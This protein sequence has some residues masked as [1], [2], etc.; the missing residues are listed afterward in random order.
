MGRNAGLIGWMESKMA[1]A[2]ATDK[3]SFELYGTVN[4]VVDRKATA[5][6]VTGTWHKHVG[7]TDDDGLAAAIDNVIAAHKTRLDSLQAN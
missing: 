6:R 2:T 5:G 7:F 4:R 1:L 3:V